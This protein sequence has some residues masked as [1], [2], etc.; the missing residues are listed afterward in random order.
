MPSKPSTLLAASLGQ[1]TTLFLNEETVLMV[2]TFVLVRLVPLSSFLFSSEAGVPA[3]LKGAKL[4]AFA[5][6]MSRTIVRL[7]LYRE[8]LPRS[9]GD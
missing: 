8:C 2:Q 9:G 7:Y 4:A 5:A 6:W 3:L 1:P